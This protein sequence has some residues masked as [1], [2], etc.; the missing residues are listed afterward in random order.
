MWNL[1]PQITVVILALCLLFECLPA[2]AQA[3]PSE[4]FT[5]LKGNKL[6][7]ASPA[8]SR[9]LEQ[10]RDRPTTQSVHL[11]RIKPEAVIGSE[12]KI[13]I[14]N[15]KTFILSKTGGDMRDSKDFTWTGEVQG[16]QRGTATLIGRDG[17][18]LFALIWNLEVVWQ[19]RRAAA[20]YS[21]GSPGA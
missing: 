5:P 1:N 7:D 12:L 14:P 13:S 3:D 2:G 15:G 19:W 8:Q 10:I 4:L 20:A 21:A 16:E 6:I 9:R 18:V 11:L 17:D